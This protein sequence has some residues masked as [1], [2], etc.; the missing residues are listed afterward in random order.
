[1]RTQQGRPLRV[2]LYSHD[3]VGLGH[4]RRNLAIAHALADDLPGR[5]GRAVTGMLITG[6]GHATALDKPEGFDVVVLPGVAKGVAGY[7]PRHVDMPMAELAGLREAM[8]TAAVTCFEPDLFIVDR[9]AH[10]VGGE[11]RQALRTLRARRPDAALVLG[12]REVLDAPE[13]AAREWRQIGDLGELAGLLDR[14]WVYGDPAVHDVRRTGELPRALHGHVRYTGYLARGRR[15]RRETD[16][17]PIPYVLTMVGGGSD[18]ADLCRVA[19]Q[20]PLPDGYRHVVVTGPQMPGPERAAIEALAGPRTRVVGSVP[21]GLATIRRAAAVV[22]MAG[23]NTVCE[24]MSTATPALLVPREVPRLEQTIRARGLAGAGAVDVVRGCD[25]TPHRLGVWIAGAVAGRQHRGGLDL[26][27]LAA[28][29]ALAAELL[30]GG[31][32]RPGTLEAVD[33]AV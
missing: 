2:L 28:V 15:W 8:L 10:G 20:A 9:H 13:V 7:E 25:L 4:I 16:P 19:A 29:P 18:G 3:S 33:A 26:D 27:G 12:L 22:S 24:V 31:P 1:M 5:T 32:C 11:L 17:T 21:D 30:A 14:I 6:S 23:Y